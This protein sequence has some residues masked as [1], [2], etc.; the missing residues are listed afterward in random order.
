MQRNVQSYETTMYDY[1]QCEYS[2]AKRSAVWMQ[3]KRIIG[4]ATQEKI[5]MD[6]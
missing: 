1:K 2:T 3:E 6:G 5:P 4:K